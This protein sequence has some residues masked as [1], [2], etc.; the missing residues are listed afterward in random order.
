MYFLINRGISPIIPI[1]MGKGLGVGLISLSLITPLPMGE[2]L[3]EG[4]EL[5]I[6]FIPYSSPQALSTKS[7]TLPANRKGTTRSGGAYNQTYI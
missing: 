5:V 2:G 3:G 1:P 6:G 4:L 7:T